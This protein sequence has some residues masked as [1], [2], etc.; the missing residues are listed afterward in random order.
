MKPPLDRSGGGRKGVASFV[1]PS[2]GLGKQVTWS[3][4]TPVELRMAIKDP[5]SRKHGLGFIQARIM[6]GYVLNFPKAFLG[7]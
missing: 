5:W 4:P 7:R 3:T 6:K 1:I 2:D